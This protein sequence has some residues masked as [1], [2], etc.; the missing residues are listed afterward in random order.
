MSAFGA[1]DVLLRGRSRRGFAYA[2]AAGAPILLGVL[3]EAMSI[4]SLEGGV[5]FLGCA[6][7]IVFFFLPAVA[8]NGFAIVN[9]E[10]RGPLRADRD[11]IGFRGRP[12]LARSRIRNVA[13]EALSGGAQIV[14]VAASRAKYDVHIEVADDEKARALVAALALDPDQHVATFSVEE[15]PLRS[16]MR[17]LAARALIFLGAL[18]VGGAVLYV[19]REEQTLLLALVP[20]LLVYSLLLP[21]ARVRTDIALAADGLTLRHRGRTRSIALTTLAEV[22]SEAH[23]ARLVLQSGEELVLRFGAAEDE[24]AGIQHHAFVTRTRQALGRCQRRSERDPGE[25]LLT[26]G[27]REKDEWA[28]HLLALSREDEGYRVATMPADTLWRIAEGTV[29][30]PT[31]RVGALVALR[32]RLDDDARARLHDLA[33]RTAQTDVRAALEAAADGAAPEDIIEA[34]ERASKS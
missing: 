3:C 22:R 17:W 25:A 33:S 11:G 20:A 23:T 6:E 5:A 29:A 32:T 19:A 26:R 10:R 27:D 28:R 18:V 21:R 13:I 24:K 12:L 8:P 15:D 2:I 16:R 4:G 9:N 31:A 14:H 30:E 7:V 1:S 34:Y